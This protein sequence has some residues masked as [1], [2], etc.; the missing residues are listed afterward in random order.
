M[1]PMAQY[2]GLDVSLEETKACV[3][4]E[5]GQTLWRGCCASTPD[6]IEQLVC[7]HAPNAMRVGLE[8]GMLSVWL[9]HELKK[10]RFPINLHRRPPCQSGVVAPD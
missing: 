6:E 5:A 9:F 4:D 2:V 1:H 3:V 8:T 7:K 10:R